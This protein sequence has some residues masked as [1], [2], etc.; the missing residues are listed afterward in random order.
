MAL[1]NVLILRWLAKRGLEGRTTLFQRVGNSFTNLKAG[2][3]GRAWEP[4]RLDSRLCGHDG[5]GAS[6]TNLG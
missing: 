3:Q 5:E 2:G 6:I 1:R 4:V